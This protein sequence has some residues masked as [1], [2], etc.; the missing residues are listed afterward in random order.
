MSQKKLLVEHGAIEVLAGMLK[1]E[2]NI[3]ERDLMLVLDSLEGI[4]SIYGCAGSMNPY[5]EQFEE[6]EGLDHLE[7]IQADEN[8][9]EEAY[10]GIVNL[11]KKYYGADD[12]IVYEGAEGELLKDAITAKIDTNTNQFAFGIGGSNTSNNSNRNN[13]ENMNRNNPF[14]GYSN[15][16]N[17][18][19]YQF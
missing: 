16:N 19:I 4:L 5:A 17:Q 1:P 7:R 14:G 11:F 3:K 18:Q 13:M 2:N 10:D 15:V 6:L 9:S 8:L 12:E